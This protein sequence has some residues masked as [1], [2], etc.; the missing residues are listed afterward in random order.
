MTDFFKFSNEL[1]CL[2]NSQGYFVRVNPAWSATLGWSEEELLGQPYVDLVHPEDKEST[3]NEAQRLLSEGYQTIR[4]ENRYRCR[5]GTYRWL[6]WMSIRDENGMIVATARDVTDQ[7]QQADEL[8]TSEERLRLVMEATSDAIWDVDLKAKTVWCNDAFE[9]TFGRLNPETNGSWEWWID[10]VHPDEREF[11]LQS[12]QAQIASEGNRWTCEH[13]FRRRDGEYSF[14]LNRALIARADDGTVTRVLGAMQDITAQK[15]GE[16]KLKT[17][18]NTIRQLFSL[19]ERERQLVSSD[20]HDGLAQFITAA[21][22]HL[23]ATRAKISDDDAPG[24]GVACHMLQRAMQEARRLITDLRPLIIED[25]G[26]SDS[27]RHAI[28]DWQRASSCEFSFHS[29]INE[30][31]V[32]DVFDGVV[33]RIVQE[34]VN[35]ALRHGNATSIRIQLR[36]HADDFLILIGDDGRGFRMEKVSSSRFGIRGIKERAEMFGG[37]ACWDSTPG[38]G[39]TLKVHMKVPPKEFESGDDDG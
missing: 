19:Q 2:A 9:A 7:K 26:I 28:A 16:E 39:T 22:F 29:E 12:L 5:D 3:L 8:R 32:S 25:R 13:R 21:I 1:L 20:I 18:A 10:Q 15:E 17:K 35:N 37:C 4:F 33:F 11:V 27:I 24:F 23:E 31:R 30:E 34:G 6:A 14:V 36:Q 38:S